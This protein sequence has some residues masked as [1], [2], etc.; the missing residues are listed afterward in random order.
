M[1][2]VDNLKTDQCAQHTWLEQRCF[3]VILRSIL[4]SSEIWGIFIFLTNHLHI[5]CWIYLHIYNCIKHSCARR[6]TASFWK[7]WKSDG[8]LQLSGKTQKVGGKVPEFMHSG[9]IFDKTNAVAPMPFT[10]PYIMSSITF[11]VSSHYWGEV[12]CV[13]VTL[14]ASSLANTPAEGNQRFHLRTES[15]WIPVTKPVRTPLMT[16]AF[17]P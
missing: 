1:T 6:V 11:Y 9:K 17:K 10:R 12:M 16:W 14:P 15:L 2:N 4:Y 5:V 7:T 3:I 8:I 13:L